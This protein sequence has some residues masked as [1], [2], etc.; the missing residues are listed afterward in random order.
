MPWDVAKKREYSRKYY[1]ENKLRMNKQ[2][3]ARIANLKAQGLC[4]RCG[5]LASVPGKEYCSDCQAMRAESARKYHKVNGVKAREYMRLW[6]AKK[7]VSWRAK[8]L[9]SQCGKAKGTWK[10]DVW[11]T[12]RF[13]ASDI[14]AN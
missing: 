3:K 4:V 13:A 2:C 11:E 7:R 9:C 8:G 14:S 6:K 12:V 5:K 10:E 1:R